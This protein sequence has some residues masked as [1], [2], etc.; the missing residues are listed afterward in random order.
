MRSNLR[1]KWQHRGSKESSDERWKSI[2]EELNRAG[3]QLSSGAQGM[4]DT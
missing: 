1:R 2:T 4:D 3:K